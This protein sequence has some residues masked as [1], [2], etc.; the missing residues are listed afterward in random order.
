M[1]AHE[2]LEALGCLRVPAG[3]CGEQI[4]EV[5]QHLADLLDVLRGGG[6]QAPLD[7]FEALLEQ[8]G[9]EQVTDVLVGLGGFG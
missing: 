6:L 5:G 8:L 3:V 9:A 1:L 7:A 2:L 4:G